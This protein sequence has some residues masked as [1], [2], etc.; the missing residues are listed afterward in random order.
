VKTLWSLGRFRDVKVE[1]VEDEAGT[2]VIFRV[3]P[4]P[5]YTL[6][7]VRLRP[8][9]FG[10]Q[11]SLLPG[12][13][14]TQP[15][16]NDLATAALRQLL[17][18]G[19]PR[20]K[21]T[22]SLDPVGN[23][24]A[25]VFLDI[26]PGEAVKVTATGDTTIKAPKWYYK[27]ALDSHAARLQS[28]WISQ[29]YFDTKVQ[30]TE[31]LGLKHA[32][33]NFNVVKGQFYHKLDMP[34]ICGCLFKERREAERQGILDFQASIDEDGKYTIEKGRQ[35]T[36]GRITFIGNS[37]FSDSFVR[38]HFILDEGVPFDSWKL[39]QSVVRLNRAGVFA[40]LDEHQVH[41]QT[42]EKTGIA[43][44][45]V[46]LSEAKRGRWSLSGPLPLVGSISS[47]LP[48]WGSGIFELSTYT[49]GFNAL[50]YS[51]ILKLASNRTFLPILALERP[52]TPGGGW[53]SGFAIAPQMGPQWMVLHY[54]ATQL[55]Q[56]LGPW[57]AGTRV[58]DL[59]VNMARPN[60][61]TATILCEAPKPRLRGLRISGSIALG[62]MRTLAN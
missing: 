26:V 7:E 56:R 38:S 17:E 52:F 23:N 15:R 11:V 60:G 49:L 21:V 41:I 9:S 53:L 31:E 24:K 35:Y 47:R 2:D 25:D 20:A 57:L 28:H 43:D 45:V 59:T 8:H 16:A 51:T 14:V 19:Y 50:A 40:P 48:S 54:A 46:Y 55:E 37:H 32:T 4:E 62:V 44:V 29:G 10:L 27:E 18:K 39:R 36:V 5:Q 61:D 1:T 42:N 33:V 58:P 6:R 3:T 12:T 22:A 13:I 34:T 30:T